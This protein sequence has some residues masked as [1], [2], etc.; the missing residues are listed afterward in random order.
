MQN[1]SI[2]TFIFYKMDDAHYNGQYFADFDADFTI[3][4]LFKR[5][6]KWYNPHQNRQNTDHYNE[7]H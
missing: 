2:D 6:S 7:H 4:K 5:A 3:Q 1:K